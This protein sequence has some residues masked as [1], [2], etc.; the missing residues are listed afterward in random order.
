MLIANQSGTLAVDAEKCYGFYISHKDDAELVI[1][2]PGHG[3]ATDVLGRYA[4]LD[5]ARDAMYKLMDAYAQGC[6]S[7]EMPRSEKWEIQERTKDARV[8]RKGGS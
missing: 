3:E 2:S 5:E 8:K 7:F 4:D 6:A 1:A